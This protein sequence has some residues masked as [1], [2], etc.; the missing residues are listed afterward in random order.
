MAETD[1]FPGSHSRPEQASNLTLVMNG[2]DTLE[3][4]E[5]LNRKVIIE[6]KEGTEQ[7]FLVNELNKTF[8]ALMLEHA[9]F[10]T[11]EDARYNAELVANTWNNKTDITEYLG[12]PLY[13][14]RTTTFRTGTECGI[15]GDQLVGMDTQQACTAAAADHISCAYFQYA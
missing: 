13:D 8:H 2:F 9:T 12:H 11:D 15:R 5:L 14:L 10:P 6:P 7:N 3:F 1:V 4:K